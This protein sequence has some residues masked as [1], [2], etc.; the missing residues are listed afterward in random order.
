LLHL[1]IKNNN[2]L[3]EY[4]T[5][6]LNSIIVKMQSDR[7]IGGSIIKHWIP[8]EIEKVLIPLIDLELQ[9]QIEC[10]IQQSFALRKEA[11]RLLD[12]AKQ[13]VE[14]AIEQD[15]ETAIKWL[16]EV[17]IPETNIHEKS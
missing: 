12:V 7:D 17:T 2:V 14:M 10:K 15:E 16:N 8:S 13:A 1:K 4:L 6:V 9:Q 3:P 11:K 5:S